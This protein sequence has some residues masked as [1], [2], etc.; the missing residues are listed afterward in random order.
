MKSRLV[1]LSLPLLVCGCATTRPPLDF[2]PAWSCTVR[3]TVD[4]VDLSVMR[5]LDA[6]G[7][8]LDVDVQWW[9]GKFDR[10]RLS[11]SRLENRKGLGDLPSVPRQ[12]LV[13]W[14]GFPPQ[15]DRERLLVVLHRSGDPAN[16]LDG[17]PMIPY[18]NGMI[19]ATIPWQRVS[20]LEQVS[21]SAQLSLID[22][23]GRVVRSSPVDLSAFDRI[24]D[25]TR[26]ALQETR[27]KAATFERS[28]EPVTEWMRL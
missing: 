17:V 26:A 7:V 10:G 28:C 3:T 4:D 6:Q 23:K 1:A 20:A 18:L 25:R 16:P 8:Q 11:F 2:R 5:T 27:T 9:G 21:R 14:F 19:G 22:R 15:I 24:V 13:S 12:L